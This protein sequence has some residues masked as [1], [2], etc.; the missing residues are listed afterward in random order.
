MESQEKKP[1]LRRLEGVAV[2]LKNVATRHIA[3]LPTEVK[4]EVKNI[5]RWTKN[6]ALITGGIETGLQ[7]GQ[8]YFSSEN[9]AYAAV[10]GAIIGGALRT[11]IAIGEGGFKA[12]EKRFDVFYDRLMEKRFQHGVFI[13]LPANAKPIRNEEIAVMK[14]YAS[15]PLQKKK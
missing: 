2:A 5:A 14:A 15:K 1:P 12:L 3:T 9:L 6:G 10:A 8:Q 13:S 4:K 7:V 11:G